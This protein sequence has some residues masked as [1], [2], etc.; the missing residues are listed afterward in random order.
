MTASGQGLGLMFCQVNN[1]QRAWDK[2]QEQRGEGK[3]NPKKLS[4]NSR[5]KRRH[6]RIYRNGDIVGRSSG[7]HS[8]KGKSREVALGVETALCNERKEQAA[9]TAVPLGDTF[10]G[11]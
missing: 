7:H 1:I 11:I 10:P 5:E 9:A 2:N 6:E 3:K 4:C 8:K